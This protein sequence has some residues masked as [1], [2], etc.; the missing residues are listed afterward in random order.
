[1]EVNDFWSWSFRLCRVLGTEVRIHWT[2]LALMLF[3]VITAVSAGVPWW[4]LPV[5]L[6]IPFLSVLLH[7]FG[8]IMAS[9]LVGG[10]ANLIIM[11]MFGGLAMCQA[12]MHAGR[13]FFVAAAGPLVTFMIM[14]PCLLIV[15]QGF[16][17]SVH[18]AFQEQGLLMATLAYTA[19]VNL[20]L[21]LFNLL[22]CYPLDGGRM[23]R[24][25]LWP[26]IGL[27]RAAL[28]TVWIAYACIVGLFAWAVVGNQPMMLI[29]C[30]LLLYNVVREHSA[31]R[32]GFDPFMGEQSDLEDGGSTWIERWSQRR[33]E[34]AQARREQQEREEQE[35][36][37]RLLAK[38]SEHGL[39]SLTA[40]ERES[41]QRISRRQ[42]ER[43][44]SEIS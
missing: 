19:D 40:A 11:W 28:V 24:M 27:R 42:K 6:L 21:L 25:V 17:P 32:R 29:L 12:P 10:E 18:L 34:Q 23:L 3:K 7:E 39:P 38:V 22:P 33:R 13:Q 31:L 4:W 36:L 1:M 30:F 37:D 16:T 41:L 5:L 20:F 9:R 44:E 15:Q 35:L 14:A 2:L 26:L 8:H 43:Q